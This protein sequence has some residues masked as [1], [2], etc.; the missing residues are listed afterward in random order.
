[1]G[2]PLADLVTDHPPETFSDL[3]WAQHGVRAEDFERVRVERSLHPRARALRR[4]RDLMPGDYFGPD[5]E[6]ARNIGRRTSAG[7][8]TSEVAEFHAH[9]STRR[10]LLRK[11]RVRRSIPRLRGSSCS[12]L[13]CAGRSPQPSGTPEA[14]FVG[15]GPG[16]A[17]A[18]AVGAAAAVLHSAAG[19]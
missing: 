19:R 10:P 12:A 4:L 15:L 11:L 5:L 14:A 16:R 8:F 17:P 1:M 2:R 18:H 9:P 7:D 3:F 13:P 6:L